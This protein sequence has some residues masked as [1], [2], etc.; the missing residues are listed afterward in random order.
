[1]AKCFL[2]ITYVEVQFIC[3][4][5][6]RDA[7]APMTVRESRLPHD[8]SVYT[9][10]DG[11]T[12]VG[13]SYAGLTAND[14]CS[15]FINATGKDHL[16]SQS[17]LERYFVTPDAPFSNVWNTPV[18]ADIGD[19]LFSHRFAQLLN[20]YWLAAIA[21]EALSGNFTGSHIQPGESAGVIG[22]GTAIDVAAQVQTTAQVLRCNKIWL[23]VLFAGSLL[24]FLAGVVTA[25]LNLTRK[26]P[27]TL[28]SFASALRDS[29][30][31]H[32]EMG[33]STEDGPDKARRLQKTRVVLGDVRSTEAV[34]YMALATSGQ[35]D[36]VGRLRSGRFY[37]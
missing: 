27:M 20:T 8:S 22:Q 18:L 32:A 11:L 3:D 36:E 12:T 25:G 16:A 26:G 21:P 1:M 14:F 35:G 30:Y 5:Q 34:G 31:I 23:C 9:G 24:I 29:P 6:G 28:D 33:P 4:G 7:C 17:A 13:T 19:R 37:W 15:I 2:T 10:F